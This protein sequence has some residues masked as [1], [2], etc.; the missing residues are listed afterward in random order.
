MPDPSLVSPLLE[1]DPS[2][3]A[4]IEPQIAAR[5]F[6]LPEVLVIC[7]FRDAIA[8]LVAAREAQE[9]GHLASEM[10]RL[11]VYRLEVDG[12]PIGLAQ[13]GVGAPLAAGFLEELIACGARRVVVA[14]GAGALV[15]GLT[16]G[17]VIVP[18][19]AIRDE[20]TSHHYLAASRTVEPAPTAVAAIR[21]TLDR[22]QVPYVEGSTW[23]TDAFYRETRAKLERRVAERCIS[24][25]ME[26]AALFAVARF[27]EIELGQ[28]LYA[29]DDLSGETW[30]ERGWVHH[31]TGRDQLLQLACEAAAELGR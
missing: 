3:E 19:A 22:R 27:R 8:R 10:G 16:L 9:I 24:V 21:R 23:T 5:Q 4:V 30:D 1:F 29:G 14:G 18:T 17:H 2:R 12:L 6:E 11:P 13:G 31:A 15:P 25:E 28:M 20:G 26:A 7:Y